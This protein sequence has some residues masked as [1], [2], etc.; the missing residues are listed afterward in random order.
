MVDS[1]FTKHLL[2]A[3]VCLTVILYK[4]M[5]KSMTCS[6][7]WRR[8]RKILLVMTL[9]V[10]ILLVTFGSV[11]A[12]SY[13]QEQK[14]DVVFHDEML[15][16][17][18]E[19]LKTNTDYEFVYRRESLGDLKVKNVELKDATL[20]Q[21]LDQVLRQN[22]FDYEIVDRIVIIRKLVMSQQKKEIKIMGL[23]T[24]EKK[25][26]IPGVTI[27]VKGLTIGTA[28]DADGKYVL[29]LPVVKDLAILFSFVGME[30]MEVK[31]TG[32]DTINVVLKE[33]VK[34]VDEVVITGIYTRKKESFTGSS[35]TFNSKELKMV[36]NQNL[37]QSLKTLDPAFN[38]L[39]N[40]QF[41]SDPNR[42]PDV[43][44]RGKSSIVG[45]KE[46]FGEDPNQPLFI[47]DGFETTLQTIMDLS[48]D[49]IASVTILKDAASTA[50]YGAKAANGVVVVETKVPE[51]GKLKL[52]YNGSFDVNFADLTDYNLMNAA[53]K[54]EFE[55]LAG[56]FSSNIVSVQEE[57][58][59]R[60]DRLLAN[61]K[62][63]VDTYWMSEPLRIG[64]NQRHNIY[65]EGGDEQM[66]YGLGVNYT[67]IQGVMKESRRQI[68][69]GNLDLLYRVGKLSFSNKLSVDITNSKNPVV[70][71]SEYSRANPYYPKRN[72]YGGVD[73][74]L[75]MPAVDA[76]KSTDGGIWV[77]NPLWNASLNSY[78]KGESFGVR[79]NLNLEYRPFNFLYLRVRAG[80][81]KSISIAENFLSPE[82][83]SFDQIE[84]LKKGSYSDTR[85]ESLNYEGDMT[86]T[87]GQLIAEAHQINAVVGVAF[88]ESK[89]SSKSF[90]AIG[91]PE[92]DF[93]TPAFSNSYPEYGKPGYTDSK[94]RAMNFYFNGG[95]SYKNRYLLDVN[96]RSDGSSVFGSNKQFTTTWALGLAWNIHNENFIKDNTDFF[97]MLKVRASIG[98]PG[99]QN[100]G[101]FNTITTYKFNNWMLNNF[102]TG[103]LVDAFGDPDLEW[104]KTIDKNI[105]VDLSVFNNRFH[106][107]LDYYY[108]KTD[109]LL[110]TIGM[111]LSV[112]VDKRLS[113]VGKQV[114]KGINGTI[115]YSWIYKPQE[116]INWVT[117]VT[118]RKN[119][120]Y[121]DG[122]EAKLKQ[123]NAENVS[124]NMSRYYDGGS[125]SAL[126]SVRSAGIDPATGQEIFLD[127]AG[128]PSFSYSYDNE[129]KV[130]DT[131]PD[132]EGVVGNTLLYK[133]LSVSV[134]CRYS[135]GADA[136][137]STL[138]NKVENITKD[139]LKRNQDKRAL[140]D[141][142]KNPGD[143]AKYRG[144][145]LTD[146]TPM[147]SRFVQK[148][149]YFVL[150]SIRLG[151]ELPYEW[152]KRMGLSG[153][154][155]SAYMNDICRISTIENERGID[156]PF[157]RSVSFAI[158]INL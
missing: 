131:R 15:E 136:F 11:S 41:G 105:G 100:F 19:Y 8:L 99:N 154:M 76:S 103:L 106:L 16:D 152:I 90:K 58:Q 64:L 148:N 42:L 73:K 54:L 111:A 55:R 75:E 30:T 23:V 156:Y 61:V 80:I 59:M 45:F 5:K 67:N 57:A 66:R 34:V 157:A 98:N 10:F 93:T 28:T 145:S 31:Y 146:N 43:E 119:K 108:K 27:V 4:C 97:S 37:L 135:F 22:G 36:G 38:I 132:L 18:L 51:R 133:G 83:T 118:F 78:D 128:K 86:I 74:W 35:T 94:K 17:V 82:D 71:F 68:A 69:S 24:D 50:I 70:P 2:V 92:G 40:N 7:H 46:Q 84:L 123:Y 1:P 9:K 39:E 149:N 21:V 125:P 89:N 137:N 47:L 112:G 117:S 96:L 116:R 113:N 120:A 53:E 107:T 138:Y 12:M 130:G 26:P 77:P 14:M 60:Y 124:K 114:D 104:Q 25:Q 6:L 101:S 62:R 29:K 33:N 44:I 151:Y 65:I 129:V 150:E 134:Y 56:N 140:Y 91:F 32:Q 95:Y 102:G 121:Y 87:Y 3:D 13:S 139:G 147:S 141:R 127:L 158:S 126:W 144:I 63:G 20:K 85:S 122:V 49:R 81:N 115:K 52:S 79:E 142:W 109:P 72:E 153:V 143:K 155:L 48:M 110:A 88:Q